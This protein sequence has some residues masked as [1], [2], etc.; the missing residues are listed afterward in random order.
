MRRLIDALSRRL[1]RR[2]GQPPRRARLRHGGTLG[3]GERDAQTIFDY[4]IEAAHFPAT[5]QLRRARAPPPHAADARARARLVRRLADPGRLRRGADDEA[6]ARRRHRTRRS[7][8]G[9]ATRALRALARC[10][11]CAARST[12]SA[13]RPT[14]RRRV[15]AGRSCAS[16]TRAG[17]ADD[18]RA[19]LPRAVDVRVERPDDGDRRRRHD[20]TV[21]VGAARRTSCSPST[22][23]A[24]ASRIRA[25]SGCSQQLYDDATAEAQRLMRPVLL[26]AEGFGVVPR[27]GRHRLRRRRLL[28]ARRADR[29]RQVDRH[30]R[31]LLRALRQR[32]PLRRRAAGRPSRQRRQ[33]GDQGVARRSRSAT[34]RYRAHPGGARAQR[35]GRARPRRSSNTSIPTAATR[36]H[37]R[38]QRPRAEAGGRAAARARRSPTSPSASC[39]PRATSPA[40]STTNRRKR[41]DLLDPAA[42]PGDLRHDRATRPPARPRPPSRRSRSRPGASSHS[43]GATDDAQA[44]P[45]PASTGCARCT[46]RSTRPVPRT[47]RLAVTSA[48]ADAEA[49]AATELAD[50]VAASCDPRRRAAHR[51]NGRRRTCRCAEAAAAVASAHPTRSSRDD[52]ELDAL[53]DRSS[54]NAPRRPRRARLRST[55]TSSRASESA[56]AAADGGRAGRGARRPGRRRTSPTRK[57]SS[58]PAATRTLRMYCGRISSPASRARCA[59]DGPGRA[60]ANRPPACARRR[61]RVTRSAAVVGRPGARGRRSQR[62]E[63]SRR[64]RSRQPTRRAA[65]DPHGAIEAVAADQLETEPS[66]H[67]GGHD[68]ATRRSAE[69]DRGP[70]RRRS[71][72][73]RVATLDRARAARSAHRR[74]AK[75]RARRSNRPTPTGT[76][77][78]RA[79]RHS[80]SGRPS[81]ATCSTLAPTAADG[82]SRGPRTA[83][84]RRSLRTLA[85]RRARG[86]DR[87]ATSPSCATRCSSTPKRTRGNELQRIEDAIAEAEARSGDPR[88]TRGGTRSPNSSASSAALRP[89]RE[90][91]ARRSARRAGRTAASTMLRELSDGQLLVALDDDDEF[92]VVDHRNADETAFGAHALGRRD[93]PGVA[94]PRARADRPAVALAAE[95]ARPARSDVPRRGVRLARR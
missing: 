72:L 45:Q 42:R 83:A 85:G 63:R 48:A 34:E 61:P 6:R 13:P 51:R 36:R 23:R 69:R 9:D 8:Q 44:R 74:S 86:G 11:R 14:R 12:S 2:H 76:T 84:R 30:R 27:R 82:R 32:A 26:H 70:E 25:S 46:R 90:V 29:R 78:R 79:G 28:R 3:G 24:T 20:A 87:R 59:A 15:A 77:C 41:R 47:T 33:A 50:S 57:P 19:L 60:D 75:R 35:Q 1:R 66:P 22:S 21:R 43:A 65:L 91:A 37:A 94:G 7:G 95:G 55:K 5:A 71:R 10:A 52:A 93:V 53:P 40:S 92:V 56:A 80:P 81:S 62:T 4:G 68:A 39:S 38:G 16:A 54:S 49:A 67:R 58:M 89:V 17:L 73:E 18:V 88:R 64:R 31:D